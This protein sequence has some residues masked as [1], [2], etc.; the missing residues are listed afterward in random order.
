MSARVVGQALAL[1]LTN[2]SIG[3]CKPSREELADDL[4]TS[5]ATVRRALA[6]LVEGGWLSKAIVTARNRT[7]RYTFR[8]PGTSGSVVV[9]FI[10]SKG[11]K[12]VQVN[13][14]REVLQ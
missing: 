4:C 11:L 14:S 3:W 12:S 10:G 2:D 5:E 9:P 13:K 7:A 8:V 6:E 1:D